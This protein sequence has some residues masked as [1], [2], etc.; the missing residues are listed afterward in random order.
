[1]PMYYSIKKNKQVFCVSVIGTGLQTVIN[2][3]REDDFEVTP[4]TDAEAQRLMREKNMRAGI[5]VRARAKDKP[6]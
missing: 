1:M 3:L 2:K 6:A 4:L 5:E